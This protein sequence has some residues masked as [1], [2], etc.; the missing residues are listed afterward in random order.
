[1]E[2]F[3]NQVIIIPDEA[4]K[5]TAAGIIIPES[6]RN[7]S[8]NTGVVKSVG[9]GVEGISVGDKVIY[10]PHGG[11]QTFVNEKRF[12]IFDPDAILAVIV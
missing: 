2:A 3:P 11:Y 6:S 7:K 4:E 12:F 10:E 9:E 1:M 5:I 8:V